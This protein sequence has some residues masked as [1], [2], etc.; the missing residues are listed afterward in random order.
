MRWRS[1]LVFLEFGEADSSP[2]LPQATK[3]LI[4]IGSHRLRHSS[5]KVFLDA[6]GGNKRTARRLSRYAKLDT[7]KIYDDNRQDMQDELKGEGVEWYRFLLKS[8][9]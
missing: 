1:C 3:S 7:L 5:I 4:K 2:C 6:S 9:S 8:M